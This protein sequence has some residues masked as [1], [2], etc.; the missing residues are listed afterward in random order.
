MVEKM[1]KSG[2]ENEIKKN[3]RYHL[4]INHPPSPAII[5]GKF[6]DPENIDDAFAQ[7]WRT[8]QLPD[9]ILVKL[10]ELDRVERDVALCIQRDFA[11]VEDALRAAA[12]TRRMLEE[13]LQV[14]YCIRPDQLNAAFEE[15]KRTGGKLGEVLVSLGF[16]GQRE[17]DVALYSRYL[18][19]EE[20]VPSW[21]SLG[22]LLILTGYITH[23]HLNDALERQ[24][25]SG[26]H[27]SEILVEAGHIRQHHIEHGLHIQKHLVE[28]FLIAALSLLPMEEATSSSQSNSIAM[29]TNIQV[30]ARVLARAS[31][32]ILRQPGEIIVT[33]SD[34]QRGFI[35][36]NAGSL[37]EIRSNTRAGVNLTFET[38]GLPFKE[39]IVSGLGREVT[40]G[41]NGGIITCQINGTKIMALS[42]RFILDEYSH[43]GTYAWPLSLSVNP[44]E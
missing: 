34:I 9:D 26:K 15:Q 25:A 22:E 20:K 43:A 17:L 38:D 29:S 35:D 31:V 21:L 24:L 8:N 37:V 41:P 36:V 42:Y 27:L 19:D 3:I 30:S 6:I 44:I 16:L 40:L 2:K 12:G 7:L 23:D 13:L 1:R 39:T 32:H 28:A 10:R 18:L 33:D 11:T 14:S 4:P 5:N